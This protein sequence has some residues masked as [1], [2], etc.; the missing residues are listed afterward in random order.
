MQGLPE[1][2][3]DHILREKHSTQKKSGVFSKIWNDT[4]IDLSHLKFNHN[5]SGLESQFIRST[6]AG[7]WETSDNELHKEE[8]ILIAHNKNDRDNIRSCW[9]CLLMCLILIIIQKLAWEILQQGKLSCETILLWISGK[10]I[11][12]ERKNCRSLK[13]V[14]LEVIIILYFALSWK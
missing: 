4:A 11:G 2:A 14:Y 9:I 10:V 6:W 12:L 1:N 5:S 3:W 13:A 7:N 8:K